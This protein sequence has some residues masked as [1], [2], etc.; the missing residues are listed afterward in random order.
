MAMK[1]EK[2]LSQ[3][4]ERKRKKNFDGIRCRAFEQSELSKVFSKDNT[5]TI[6]QGEDG[7]HICQDFTKPGVLGSMD[8][9]W[10]GQVFRQVIMD[11]FYTPSSWHEDRWAEAMYTTT[12]PIMA[13]K[14]AI[15]INGEVWLPNIDCIRNRLQRLSA[16]LRPWFTTKKI[17][18]PME[19]P[20][21]RATQT[22]AMDLTADGNPFTNETERK[23]GNPQLLVT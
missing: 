5:H 23:K 11:Y 10:A 18:N 16:S 21:Y 15:P 7:R 4:K 14:G 12:L 9:Q 20:L 17:S 13:A 1:S 3:V 8:S 6:D 19:N 22:V 2:M